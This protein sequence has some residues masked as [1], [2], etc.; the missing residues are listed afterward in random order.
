MFVG[1]SCQNYPVS[2]ISNNYCFDMVLAKDPEHSSVLCVDVETC[3]FRLTASSKFLPST[4]LHMD[5][6]L[7]VYLLTGQCFGILYC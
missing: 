4:L 3:D 2:N 7:T 1:S 6:V 5:Y